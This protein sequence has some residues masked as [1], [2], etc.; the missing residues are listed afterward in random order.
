MR[1]KMR[2]TGIGLMLSILVA[3]C[4][5]QTQVR[6]QETNQYFLFAPPLSL[7]PGQSSRFTLFLPDNVPIR[8][9]AKLMDEHN[10]T[11]LETPEVPVPARSPFTLT[12]THQ[13]ISEATRTSGATDFR[14]FVSV[15]TDLKQKINTFVIS[16]QTLNTS[17]GAVTDGTS[18]TILVG[19]R[20]TD[21]DQTPGTLTQNYMAS[22]VPGQPL[23]ISILN[24]TEPKSPGQ[25]ITFTYTVTNTS[26][27]VIETRP[28]IT[29][30]SNEF[31]NV[32]IDTSGWIP[33]PL[34]GR[35]NVRV[36]TVVS[37]G[38]GRDPLNIKRFFVIDPGT[39]TTMWEAGDQCLVF[40]VG[41]RP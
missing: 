16:M 22:A 31:R 1:N 40:F 36:T 3:T 28:A 23:I 25:T 12:F 5:F 26:G 11:I 4:S 33:D 38:P 30:P 18:Q 10:L 9:Q 27:N 39:L 19:E 2:W 15:T 24:P 20:Q 21:L 7:G 17:T 35:A 32:S 14:I 29:I 8:A 41:G 6:A 13:Q 34:T 37:G